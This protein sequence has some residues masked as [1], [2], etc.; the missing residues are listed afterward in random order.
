MGFENWFKK[1]R[2]SLGEGTG[3]V[4]SKDPTELTEKELASIG[5]VGGSTQAE[6]DAFRRKQAEA[7]GKID[8][9]I[10]HDKG[11][12]SPEELD[13]VLGGHQKH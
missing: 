5:S 1:H 6:V 11:E 2:N 12:M 4:K 10:A 13:N 3:S 9:R 7:I 8:A